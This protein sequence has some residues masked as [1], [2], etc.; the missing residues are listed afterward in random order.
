MREVVD[1]EVLARVSAGWICLWMGL[2]LA[3]SRFH[4][5]ELVLPS[6][7]AQCL[8]PIGMGVSK[9]F[10]PCTSHGHCVPFLSVVAVK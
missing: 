6:S 7:E 1:S 3:A 4:L 9:V 5:S 10:P 8:D 2:F